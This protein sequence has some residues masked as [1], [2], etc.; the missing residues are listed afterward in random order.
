MTTTSPTTASASDAPAPHMAGNFAPVTD[1]LTAYDLPVTGTIPPELT[2]WFL[3]NGPN[4]RDA[5]TP[6]WFFGDGMVHGLRLEGGR[7]V[8]YRN[9]WV[10]TSAL[11]EGAR[12][13]DAQG[14]RNLAAGVA[15][16]HVVRH[17]GRTLALVESAFPY[18]IDC[19]PGHELETIGAYDF[20]GRLTT[21]MTA[22]PKTCPVTGELHF[23]G[24]GG[25]TPPYL[26]YHRADASGELVLSRPI[27]VPGPTMMHDFHLTASHVVF[28]DLPV[29]FDR[30]HPGMPYRWDP[31][32]GARL[33]VLRRDDPHG[34]VRWLAIDPCYVFHALNAHDEGD[35]RIVLH[36]A[37]YAEFGGVSPAH[38]WRW[39]IDLATGTVAEEQ[40]DDHFCE[41]PRVDDRL[42][43]Q[44]AR[45]GHATTAELPGSGPIPGALLRYD[46]QTGAV[47]RHEFAPGR[48]PCEAVFAPADDRPGGPG[49][50]ITYV[51][52]ASTDTSDFVVL[53]TEDISADP[54]A[55]VHL[56]QRVPYGFHGN[57]LPD[58]AS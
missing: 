10:R 2:G 58:P 7:A 1:E 33:G 3:R 36:V 37:R 41:F 51:Y 47:V 20:G 50:L 22:H 26:T 44:P 46:L 19:R 6:H 8:S 32:Y 4:P 9:R 28:M 39:T 12:A 25:P 52:D 17:A 31:E 24:Y 14:R 55:T 34:E 30:S 18:E 23:F 54:V 40:L 56:P 45:F 15:N 48:T 35:Q 27:D 13:V 11:T 49:W 16:T 53:D 43:G 29:V 42:A 38:L 5:A 57:W 21:A